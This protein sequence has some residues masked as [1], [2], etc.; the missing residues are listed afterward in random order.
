MEK[1]EVK[2]QLG[3]GTRSWTSCNMVVHTF[4]LGDWVT[5]LSTKVEGLVKK[6]LK[7]LIYSGEKDWVCNWRGGE[8]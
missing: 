6:G 8:A 4:M 7:V 1:P 5:N 3:V 2:E